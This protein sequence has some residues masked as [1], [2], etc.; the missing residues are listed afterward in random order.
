MNGV[1]PDTIAEIWYASDAPDARVLAANNS[2]N[3]APCE[4]ASAFWQTPYATTKV[5]MMST[6]IPVFTSRNIATP[7]GTPKAH[8]QTYTGRRPTLSVSRAHPT[9]AAMPMAAAMHKATRV[10]VL[11]ASFA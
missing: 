8:T 1:N 3:H 11:L 7:N 6:S 4:P 2:G 5:A 9:V 10:S